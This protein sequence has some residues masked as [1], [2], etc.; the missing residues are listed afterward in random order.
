MYD[1]TVG[2]GGMLIQSAKY[3][4]EWGGDI[5]NLS[6]AGQELAGTTWAMCKMNM[7]LHGIVSQDIRQGDVLK[8]PMHLT[9]DHELKTWDRVIANPPFS[10][11]YSKTGM[12]F[13]HRFHTW[14]PT[15]GKQADLMFV[16]HMESVLRTDGKCAVIMP[17]GVLFR[18]GEKRNC[19]QRFI[20]SG[21]LEA[22]IGLPP[23]LFYGTGIPACI[24]VLNRDG[25]ADRDHVLFINADR[26]Y[27]EGKNQNQ[28]R[29]E[30]I[31]KITHVYH[32]LLEVDGY[33][34]LVPVDDIREE[35][36]NCNIRRYVD[37]SPPP[38]PQDVRAHLHG[39]VPIPEV[40]SL[41]PYFDNYADVRDLLFK[42]KNGGYLAFSDAVTGNGSIKTLIEQ[43]HGVQE[44]HD[45][46]RES[47][48][49]WWLDNVGGVAN[50]DKEGNV[51]EYRRDFSRSI[52]DS[53]VPEEIL[54]LHKVRG[55]FASFWNDLD[56]DFKSIAASGWSAILIPDE[57]ILQSQFPEVLAKV[58]EDK[59]RIVELEGMF[60]AAGEADPDDDDL[61]SGV[62]PKALVKALKDEKKGYNGQLKELRKELKELKADLKRMQE[63]DNIQPAE[64]AAQE[65]SISQT[66]QRIK[67]KNNS[68]D[69]VDERLKGH[70]ELERGLKDL[71]AGIRKVENKMDE[72]V[73]QA[74]EKITEEEAKKLILQRFHKEL[75]ATYD[76]YL[77]QYLRGFIA[78]VDTLWDKYAVT[79]NDILSDRDREAEQLNEFLVE[80]GYE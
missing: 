42:A 36:F 57:N 55:A 33:S 68:K 21:R 63:A 28:L 11:K 16:Q 25:A 15:T 1:P 34:R 24:L 29:P 2:S 58:E 50:L 60:A 23:S 8:E 19:R 12:T 69:D 31:A 75:L 30:H 14:M 49:K 59:A 51:F 52:A 41:Q 37:N 9:R 45:L 38:E 79:L 22:V 6:L 18:G 4:Q 62:L 53:L 13:E 74:R 44:K 78:A 3:V 76:D 5:R 71:K 65:T 40:D 47:L 72:L 46:F 64:I 54:D 67:D 66:D 77:R 26:E 27:K 43:S 80:L 56:S 10:Q 20:E 61:E 35:D 39:G 7:I 17:H 32:N 70:A 48:E 73:A